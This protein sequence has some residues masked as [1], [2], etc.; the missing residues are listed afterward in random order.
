MAGSPLPVALD[1]PAGRFPDAIEA[2][3]YFVVA[4]ALANAAKHAHASR[5]AVRVEAAGVLTVEVVDDGAGGAGFGGSGLIGIRDRV[6][7]LGG[8]LVL[9]SPPGTGTRIHAELPLR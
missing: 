8:T 7:S 2:C 5:M 6:E 4:E 3:A 1:V 9:E